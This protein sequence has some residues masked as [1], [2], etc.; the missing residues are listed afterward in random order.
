MFKMVQ[1]FG[2]PAARR[3]LQITLQVV[4]Y[5]YHLALA[6]NSGQNLF[7][8]RQS[9][10]LRLVDNDNGIVDIA[11]A[12]E[13]VCDTSDIP[14][15]VFLIDHSHIINGSRDIDV[16]VYERLIERLEIYRTLLGYC[17]G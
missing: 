13:G 17:S 14:C 15:A 9:K 12:Q 1:I 3:I 8:L 5:H 6:P 7:E 16:T 2:K 10:V 4:S 11:A